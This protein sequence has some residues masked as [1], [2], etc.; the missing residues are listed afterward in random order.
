M[1]VAVT[2]ASGFIGRR[3]VE[4]LQAAGYDVLAFGRRPRSQLEG[5]QTA[6]YTAWDITS[7]KLDRPPT[8]EAV[9][10]CAAK[11]ADWGPADEFRAVNVQGTRAVLATFP[12]ARFIHISTASVYPTNGIAPHREDDRLPTRYRGAYSGTKRTAE[13]L[14]MGQGE[15]TVVLRPHAVYGPGDLTLL[16]RLLRGYRHEFLFAIGDGKNRISLTHVDNLVHGVEQALRHP[17]ASGVFNIADAEAV[18]VDTLLR[19]LL[20]ALDLRPS[21]RYIP[22]PVALA[23]A[24]TQEVVS[25]IAPFSGPPLF[26]RYAVEQMTGNGVLDITRAVSQLEF[27]PARSHG[28]AFAEIAASRQGRRF[29]PG[30]G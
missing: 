1:R 6:P 30:A 2:G 10:H 18:S 24:G 7:G 13:R 11:V 12:N 14:V 5:P 28:E 8:A 23:I 29:R 3:V 15:A 27:R 25:R 4:H 26:T 22:R 9:V 21:I 20:K 16:P 17:A 19:D